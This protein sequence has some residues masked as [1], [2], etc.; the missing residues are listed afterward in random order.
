M[1]TS[2]EWE[3]LLLHILIITFI[4]I[5]KVLRGNNT[6]FLNISFSEKNK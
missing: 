1:P 2:N 6:K 5:Q 4:L 3:F